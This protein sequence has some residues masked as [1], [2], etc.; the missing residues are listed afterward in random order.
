M[1][2]NKKLNL[3]NY[4][5]VFSKF[6]FF[7]YQNLINLPNKP[8][9]LRLNFNYPSSLFKKDFNFNFSHFFYLPINK[10]YKSKK[11]NKKINFC[12]LPVLFDFKLKNNFYKIKP[13]KFKIYNKLFDFLI[14]RFKNIWITQEVNYTT[15]KFNFVRF[16]IKLTILNYTYLISNSFIFLN[17]NFN[18]TLY[19]K[20]NKCNLIIN[21]TQLFSFYSY[22][23][24]HKINN[25][26]P[27]INNSDLNFFF[28][29]LKNKWKTKLFIFNLVNLNFLEY[30]F[31]NR[32]FIKVRTNFYKKTVFKSILNSILLNYSEKHLIFLENLEIRNFITLYIYSLYKKDLYFIF[33]WFIVTLEK[34]PIAYHK[35]FLAFFKNTIINDIFMSYSYFNIKGFFFDIRGKVGVTGNSKK[36]NFFFT[37]GSLNFSSKNIKL[38]YKHDIVRTVTGCL[39]V[40][41]FLAYH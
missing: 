7:I 38:E 6:N 8:T 4:F 31:K 15:F 17:Q 18:N 39:G 23:F 36:R 13:I 33:N 5:I 41:M 28:L 11:I 27:F 26:Y 29:I 16:R 12:C 14:F 24:F 19:L 3:L 1:L 25:F 2:S 20:K 9:A 30:F 21:A 35:Q 10:F 22:N 32:F 37:T 40:T 34:T